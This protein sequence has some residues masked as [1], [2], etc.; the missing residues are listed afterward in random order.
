MFIQEDLFGERLFWVVLVNLET[1]AVRV[2]YDI[3][4][5]QSADEG[6]VKNAEPASDSQAQRKSVSESK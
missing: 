3:N 2:L 5:R 6:S 4:D 1:K